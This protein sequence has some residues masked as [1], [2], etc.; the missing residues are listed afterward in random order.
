MVCIQERK[1]A[2]EMAELKNFMTFLHD[3]FSWPFCDI[4][5]PCRAVKINIFPIMLKVPTERVRFHG[6]VKN[7]SGL[8][9]TPFF[10]V[11]LVKFLPQ[12]LPD[13]CQHVAKIRQLFLLF[14]L[15][16]FQNSGRFSGV[17]SWG[18]SYKISSRGSP[19]LSQGCL[20]GLLLRFTQGHFHRIPIWIY[21]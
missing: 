8:F 7:S 9:F 13:S 3:I 14:N 11:S 1:F 16:K 15:P 17:F 6:D 19:V 20:V 21:L 12:I 4:L 2:L 18:G 5:Q 10:L